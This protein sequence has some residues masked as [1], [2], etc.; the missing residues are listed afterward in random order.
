MPLPSLIVAG[1]DGEDRIAVHWLDHFVRELQAQPEQYPDE[2]LLILRAA[3]PDGLT[4]RHLENAHG[5]ALNRNFPTAHYK[6]AGKPRA[7][8]G[9]ASEP[10]TRCLLHVLF[11][12]RPQRLIHVRSATDSVV[13]YNGVAALKAQAL[14]EATQLP[15]EAFNPETEPGSLE[16]FATSVLGIEVLSLQLRSGDDWRAAG[17]APSAHDPAGSPTIG[18]DPSCGTRLRT[19]STPG[20]SR[21]VYHHACPNHEVRGGK[22]LPCGR[23]TVPSTYRG[24]AH[25]Y[26]QADHECAC[27]TWL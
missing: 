21:A 20:S 16:D 6:P 12:Y 17:V 25:D 3:N 8:D 14:A 13:G 10:E 11:Q 18:T 22:P 15:L 4:A 2:R 9:P 7:G 27:S 26:Q 23:I 1:L 24:A 5:V 19:L